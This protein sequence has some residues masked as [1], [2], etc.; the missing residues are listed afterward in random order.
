MLIYYGSYYSIHSVVRNDVRKFLFV[1]N[2]WGED[3]E[4]NTNA[5]Y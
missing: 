3:F 5:V 1:Y 2:Y 4:S